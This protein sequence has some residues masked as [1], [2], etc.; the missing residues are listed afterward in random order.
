[1]LYVKTY[2]VLLLPLVTT[3]DP[4]NS[5]AISKQLCTEPNS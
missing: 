5:L 3:I 1:M 4:A 2:R